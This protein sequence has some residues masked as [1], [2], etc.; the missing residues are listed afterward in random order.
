M[1][2]LPR[3]V[4]VLFA[5]FALLVLVIA[6]AGKGIQEV[7][8]QL[9]LPFVSLFY[10]ISPTDTEGKATDERIKDLESQLTAVTTDYVRLKALEEENRALRAQARF[11]DRSG[12]DS[13]GA[14]VIRRELQG[15]RA[16]FLIDRG[17]ADAIELGQ[18]VITD[19]GVLIGKLTQVYDQ[20][21][22]VTLIAD[23]KSR[24]ASALQGEGRLTGILEGKGNGATALTYIPS[25]ASIK[26]DQ[27]LITAGTEEKIPGN[28]PIGFVSIVEGKPTDPFL[29]AS[30]ESLVR[31]D[32][33][34]F[35]SVLRPTAL[36]P[37]L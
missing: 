26:P 31:F 22:E 14:R 8:Q 16:A 28:L 29:T 1:F 24:I 27:L 23:G 19:N 25:S 34:M 3:W 11:L 15:Q 21:A 7:G 17:R 35:V 4:I 32:E 10:R 6:G 18:A 20:V 13:V 37:S 12:Y 9:S 30:V 2:G 36:A 5:S 33:V